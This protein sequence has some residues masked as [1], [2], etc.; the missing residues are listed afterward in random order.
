[1]T[2]SEM[3]NPLNLLKKT[4]KKA[5]GISGAVTALRR[6]TALKR[7]NHSY[8]WLIDKTKTR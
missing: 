5:S 4:P 2:F 8:S 1:M 7:A 6:N 3:T